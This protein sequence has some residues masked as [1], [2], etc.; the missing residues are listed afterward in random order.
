[1][2]S[3]DDFNFNARRILTYHKIRERH[4]S[5]LEHQL[6]IIK[7]RGIGVTVDDGDVSFFTYL[8]PLLVKHKIPS[9][10]F[11][12]T[13]LIDTDTPF[14]W[15]EVIYYL[16]EPAGR[17]KLRQL[18][19]IPNHERLDFLQ[20]MRKQSG[21]PPMHYPQLTTKQLKEMQ[22][23]GVVIG[24][25]SHTHPMFDQCTEE[26]I[27]AELRA[28]KF[29]FEK[30]GLTGY[31]VLAYPNGNYNDHVEQI[32]KDEGVK[33]AFLF[34]HRLNRSRI[35]PLRTSR[36]SVNDDTPLWKFRLIISGWHSRLL[37]LRKGIQQYI[38]E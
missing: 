28:S 32:L 25:H 18:K 31:S 20:N 17:E 4:V 12:I 36:L 24:N 13:S 23:A 37:P 9:I 29:I 27:R 5:N 15:D 14:W 22:D 19:L 21:K 38:H 30:N 16:G 8:Y 1:M 26:E 2:V 35:N 3:S 11:I 6:E 33:Q 10:L 7:N 34:D